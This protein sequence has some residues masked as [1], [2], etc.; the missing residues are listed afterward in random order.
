MKKI[1]V[2]FQYD[3]I[4]L[5]AI[6]KYLEKKDIDIQ[7]ELAKSLDALYNKVVPM[8]VREF[9]A[10]QNGETIPEQSK[11]KRKPAKAKENNNEGC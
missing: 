7:T 6:K 10:M 5:D 1:A 8:Q 9:L 3:D 2:T 4:K 11:S